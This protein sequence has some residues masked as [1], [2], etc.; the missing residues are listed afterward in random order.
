MR[1]IILIVLI[2]FTAFPVNAQD[3]DS[4]N[5]K[6]L[7]PSFDSTLGK[8]DSTNYSNLINSSPVDDYITTS[9][10]Y[11]NRGGTAEFIEAKVPS[12]TC[13]ETSTTSGTT[14]CTGIPGSDGMRG[15]CSNPGCYDRAKIE[16][17]TQNNPDDVKYAIQ[18]ATNAAFTTGVQ[19]ISGAN[20]FPKTS[21]TLSDFLYKCEWEGTVYS[22]YCV[23]GNTTY[24]KY[25]IL[26]LTPNTLYY[27][28]V[29]ALKGATSAASFTQSDWG[30]SV[31]ATTQNTSL[32][33]DIDI[34]PNTSTSTNPPYKLS[35]VNIIP[36]STFT[37]A[38]YV[39]FKTT[40]NALN[41]IQVGIRTNA[42]NL[43][44]SV[45]GDTIA[46][47]TG[48]LDSTTSGF[49]L[50]NDSSTN[51]QTN[52]GNLGTITVSSSPTD[53]T[54]SG[55]TN[56]VGGPSTTL[57][58]LFTSN[59]LPLFNGVSGYKLKVRADY[60]KAAG[61]YNQTLTVIPTGIY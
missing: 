57:T 16:I 15:V 41:G 19:Y 25:N 22:S 61:E 6:L 44:N 55:A 23:S 9:T 31:T 10:N 12:V 20:R 42:N 51:S 46:S 53:F 59:S 27:L 47:Y 3:L 43:V 24:T 40:T 8:A 21:L 56:R 5:Y 14:N 36:E 18:I 49:G 60:S 29:S 1:K 54:D 17:N 38:D 35:T 37:S 33:F 45:S 4:T 32:S 50:R 48:D 39:V 7:A 52:S 34:A 2:F 30:A 11:R 13:F 28:R 58:N 26:G